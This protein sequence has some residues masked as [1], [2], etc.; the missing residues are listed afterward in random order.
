MKISSLSA[1]NFLVVSSVRTSSYR[2]LHHR[3]TAV[4]LRNSLIRWKYP[5]SATSKTIAAMS[6]LNYMNTFNKNDLIHCPKITLKNGVNHPAI[7][8]G[9]Y[10]LGFI[11]ASASSATSSSPS[12]TAEEAVSNAIK[13]G[14]RFIE[15]AQFYGNEEQVGKAISECG[16]PREAIVFVW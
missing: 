6:S 5:G 9:T 16:I 3:E 12:I 11:P 8:F 7:G 2:L 1:I 10:K 4:G 13:C 15:C 14:Y